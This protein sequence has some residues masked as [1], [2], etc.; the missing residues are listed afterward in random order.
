MLLRYAIEIYQWRRK[1]FVAAHA[2]EKLPIHP[3]TVRRSVPR[4]SSSSQG[5]KYSVVVMHCELYV[6]Y[7]AEPIRAY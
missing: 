1:K 2:D 5:M 7:D 4:T 6:T 3:G